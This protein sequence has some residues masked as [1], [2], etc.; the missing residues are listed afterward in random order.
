[1]QL[2]INGVTVAVNIRCAFSWTA[3][4]VGLLLDR[5]L[6]H[7]TAL[8]LRPCTSVHTIGMAYPIDVVFLDRDGIVQKVVPN[9]KPLR[10]AAASRA[11]SVMEFRGGEAE[12]LAIRVGDRLNAA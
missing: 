1:M 9:L 3:R 5:D 10:F 2:Q 11:H 8:W 6:P 4:A 7:S 12:R